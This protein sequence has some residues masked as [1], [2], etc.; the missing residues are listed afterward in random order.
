MMTVAS[1]RNTLRYDRELCTGCGLCRAVCPHG[2]F[3]WDDGPAE[4]VDPD[5][6]MECGACQENCPTGALQVESGVGC[7]YAMFKAAL[8]GK[9]EPTCGDGPD[10]SCSPECK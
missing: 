1:P 4:L 10:P 3:G 8:R 2:V 9:K 5:A 7:A 6:C